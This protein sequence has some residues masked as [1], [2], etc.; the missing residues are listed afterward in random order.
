MIFVHFL[1]DLIEE[2]IE[3]AFN[4]MQLEANGKL[5]NFL[6]PVLLNSPNYHI[7]IKRHHSSNKQER[8]GFTSMFDCCTA[9]PLSLFSSCLSLVPVITTFCFY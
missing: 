1:E 3:V 2:K 8:M 9:T 6:Q 4:Q 7:F 5:N